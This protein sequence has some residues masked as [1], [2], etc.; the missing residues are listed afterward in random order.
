MIMAIMQVSVSFIIIVSGFLYLEMST[1]IVEML[2]NT[3]SVFILDQV[4]NLASI[5]L[6]N[7]VRFRYPMMTKR[8][9]FMVA[10]F[11]HDT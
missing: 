4:V 10:K 2:N 6:F 8:S 11:N 3:L 1:T 7:W 9:S 5:V